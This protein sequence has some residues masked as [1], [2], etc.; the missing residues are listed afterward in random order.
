M[1]QLAF[2]IVSLAL[3]ES[4]RNLLIDFNLISSSKTQSQ[5]NPA[6]IHFNDFK[7]DHLTNQSSRFDAQLI[8]SSSSS[9]NQ[10]NSLTIQ[11][12][13]QLSPRATQ[14]LISRLDATPPILPQNVA[15]I[16]TMATIAARLGL[17]STSFFAELVVE[18]IRYTTNTTVGLTRR[19]LTTAVGGARS[20]HLTSPDCFRELTENDMELT[21][22]Q[23]LD[24][25]TN[26][27]IYTV[28]H[29]FTLSELFAMAGLN[30]TQSAISTGFS[31]AEA[32]VKVMDSI[33]GSNESSRALSAIIMLVRREFLHDPRFTPSHINTLTGL[34]SLT[35]AMTAFACLQLAT[36]RRSMANM[37]MRVV[38]D[39][40][41]MDEA[42]VETSIFGN[43]NMDYDLGTRAA[44]VLIREAKALRE[45]RAQSA[46]LQ[47]KLDS[48]P[49]SAVPELIQTP[50]A[51]ANKDQ[52]HQNY[53][54]TET[55]T[56]SASGNT[57]HKDQ[58]LTSATRWSISRS[59][60]HTSVPILTCT[61]SE[62]TNLFGSDDTS[63]EDSQVDQTNSEKHDLV[64]NSY[65]PI[66]LKELV[67]PNEHDAS[68]YQITT[69]ITTTTATTVCPV[70]DINSKSNPS[71]GYERLQAFHSCQRPTYSGTMS[72]VAESETGSQSVTTPT[73]DT[74]DVLDHP[75][76]S[77]SPPTITSQ[78]APFEAES[79]ENDQKDLL[80]EPSTL[81]IETPVQTEV[82]SNNNHQITRAFSP[83]SKPPQSCYPPNS[84]V[85]NLSYFMKF[86]SAAY[87]QQFLRVMGLGSDSFN[88]PNTRK[89]SG[90][91]H[92]FASHVGLPVDQILYSSFADSKPTLGNSVLSPLVHYIA[93]DHSVKSIV[94]TCRGTLGLSDI[95]VDLTCQYEPIMVEGGD[96]EKAYLA[97]SGMLHSA[98]RLRHQSSLVHQELK[99]ALLDHPD[100]GLII[101]GHSLGGGVASLLAVL[102]ST[103]SEVYLNELSSAESSTD[104]PRPQL[105][106][107]TKFVTSFKSGLPHGRPIHCYCYGPPAVSSIDLSEYLVGLV[108]AVCNGI[109]VVPTLSLGVLHD[110]KNVAVSIYDEEKISGEIVSK[111]IGLYSRK[112]KSEKLNE[113]FNTS[114]STGTTENGN[115]KEN[116]NGNGKEKGKDQEEDGPELSDWFWSLKS[117]MKAASDSEK[118]YPPGEVWH[119]EKYEVYPNLKEE[120]EMKKKETENSSS[121]ETPTNDDPTE[122]EAIEKKSWV[123]PNPNGMITVAKSW[124]KFGKLEASLKKIN[125]ISGS[126]SGSG[127]GF[128]S[129][130]KVKKRGGKRV[131]LRRCDDL[132]ARFSEP[133]FGKSMFHDHLPTQYEIALGVLEE[134][135]NPKIKKKKT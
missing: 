81:T 1:F 34:I 124:L 103:R 39:A 59:N 36:S 26:L 44:E 32:S 121:L 17:R 128:G 68:L 122:G 25:Y 86:S 62:G 16:I 33:F 4:Y 112:I 70:N 101:T 69:T 132:V 53:R 46:A 100:Y 91:H 47:N 73:D 95:L 8:A 64:P 52:A 114:T 92:A 79:I 37:K 118:L 102:F 107:I 51:I 89:H 57:W 133:I 71:S 125:G 78:P 85:T 120:E 87:G 20:N 60:S 12:A 21:Y 76:R 130:G 99:Q 41:V 43:A 7:N 61:D 94:L 40:T 77:N 18:S 65:E 6:Y 24:R 22:F 131:V 13:Y 106:I 31:T 127:S 3:P 105:P 82:Q 38:W 67:N 27:G 84:L 30:L 28:H 129:S 116:E 90:N 98:L 48:V 14:D 49:S 45:E 50:H 74:F 19:A 29:I 104:S 54:V 56:T 10:I 83:N 111:V 97:H 72:V 58:G 110:F 11:P 15:N 2:D 123:K 135:I 23:L 119:V 126:G 117:T 109:D 134:A 35:K 108:T 115:G 63:D 42:E 9:S 93:V 55:Q 5:T 88:Y 80:K 66:P 113:C 75:I 96:S